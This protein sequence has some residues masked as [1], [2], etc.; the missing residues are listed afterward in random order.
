MYESLEE[1]WADATKRVEEEKRAKEQAVRTAAGDPEGLPGMSAL[2]RQFAANLTSEGLTLDMTPASMA[3]LDRLLVATKK[4]LASMPTG[5]RNTFENHASLNIGAYVGEVLRLQEGGFWTKG[6]D[7]LPAVDLGWHIVPVMTAVLGFL[8][9]GRVEMPG[10]PVET[11]AA[12]YRVASTLSREAL[13]A[14]VRG[15][16]ATLEAL[17]REMTDN[18]ELARWLSGQAHLAVKTA[19]TR[20]N[21]SLDFTPASLQIVENIL[22]QLHDVLKTAPAAERPT[23]QQVET[24]A[25]MWGVYVGEVIRRHIAGKWALSD[26]VLQL[27]LNTA[28]AFPLRK[29]QK[30]LIDGP[31]DA[32]PFYF[33]TLKHFASGRLG[34]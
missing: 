3:V 6:R 20:W 5:E 19:K 33:H 34:M 10:G 23:D 8:T 7:G 21:A 32:I 4:E 18:S 26:G 25:K 14:I 11:F 22:A 17:E 15:P 1:R 28:Q 24:A 29:V 2:A 31:G 13:E 12:Y 16:H 30:R 9:R 27:E